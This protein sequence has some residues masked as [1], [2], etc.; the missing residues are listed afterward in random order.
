MKFYEKPM[1]MI[2]N[3]EVEDVMLTSGEVS[4]VYAGLEE[5]GADNTIIFEW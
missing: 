4:E 1:A 3:V 2:E 5:T